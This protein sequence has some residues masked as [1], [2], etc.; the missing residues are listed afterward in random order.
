MYFFNLRNTKRIFKI[1]SELFLVSVAMRDSI[2]SSYK[3][4]VHLCMMFL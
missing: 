4:V 3:Y 1:N 2:L